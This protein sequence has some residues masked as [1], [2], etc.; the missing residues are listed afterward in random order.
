[1]GGTV[2]V[3]SREFKAGG[4]TGLFEELR[5]LSVFLVSFSNMVEYVVSR[6]SSNSYLCWVNGSA[7]IDAKD[8]TD[9]R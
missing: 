4:T 8:V 7:K 6:K 1:M 9:P 2:S 3:R 5:R